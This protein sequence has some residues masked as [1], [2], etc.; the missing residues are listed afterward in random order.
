MARGKERPRVG[1]AAAQALLA[2]AL[3]VVGI[4]A[5]AAG[6]VALGLLTLILL[7]GF[8]VGE[9][10]LR[11]GSEA[12]LLAVAL[13]RPFFLGGWLLALAGVIISTETSLDWVIILPLGVAYVGLG[14]F[15]LLAY[16]RTRRHDRRSDADATP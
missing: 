1:R 13:V 10:T 2:C 16:Q 9:I 6:K 12:G 4:G 7:G 14:V 3:T 8:A 15:L 5:V 11:R